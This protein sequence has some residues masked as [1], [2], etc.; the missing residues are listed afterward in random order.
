MFREERG[1]TSEKRAIGIFLS[2]GDNFGAVGN[3]V[4]NPLGAVEG[5]SN[6]ALRYVHAH[7]SI[8]DVESA[9]VKRIG[10]NEV[11]SIELRVVVTGVAMS[12]G[13]PFACDRV[14][15][16][17]GWGTV[18]AGGTYP[19]LTLI[20]GAGTSPVDPKIVVGCVYEDEPIGGAAVALGLAGHL[21]LNGIDF[22]FSACS[23]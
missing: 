1:A 2:I 12:K 3:V 16:Q 19:E 18:G 10:V 6:A 4:V 17:D 11:V 5:K 20:P 21:G 22:G 8:H 7:P 23:K 9:L 15:T 13:I 14:L